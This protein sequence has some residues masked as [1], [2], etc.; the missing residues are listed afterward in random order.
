MMLAYD[1]AT[2][3]KLWST[4]GPCSFP[5]RAVVVSPDSSTVYATGT[6]PEFQGYCTA[7]YDAGTGAVRWQASFPTG[8]WIHPTANSLALSPDGSA[9]YVTG[10]AGT[11]AYAAGTGTQQWAAHYKKRWQ[12]TNEHVAVSPDGAT[13]FVAGSGRPGATGAGH[14]LTVAYSAATGTQLWAAQQA[15][16]AA[17][18]LVVGPDSTVFVAAIGFPA[19]TSPTEYLAIAYD[20][21]TGAPIWVRRSVDDEGFVAPASLAV[22]QDGSALYLAGTANQSNNRPGYQVTG[23]ATA[24]GHRLWLAHYQSPGGS[25]STASAVAVTGTE[26]VVIGSSARNGGPMTD[27]ATVALQR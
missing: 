3:Q 1:A 6:L 12:R 23:Y 21:A 16:G 9:L 10:T 22:S 8:E 26:V 7:A 14:I 24:T 2:G 27:Y 15:E 20:P 4:F 11:V 18:S 25:A 19:G 13:V 17:T 5:V